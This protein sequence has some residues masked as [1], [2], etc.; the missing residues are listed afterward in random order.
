M[1]EQQTFIKIDVPDLGVREF[2]P[3]EYLTAGVLS[4]VKNWYGD[5]GLYWPFQVALNNGDPDAA[6]C[7]I[8]AVRR[9]EDVQPNPDPGPNG[10]IEDFSIPR[11]VFRPNRPEGRQDKGLRFPMLPPGEDEVVL[12]C[13]EHLTRKVMRMVKRWYP[14]FA[15]V[16]GFTQRLNLGD[17]DAARCALWIAKRAAGREVPKRPE[18][19]G[20]FSIGTVVVKPNMPDEDDEDYVAP[21]PP[22][23]EHGDE[24]APDPLEP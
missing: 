20:D 19:M 17:P 11:V 2:R 23:D 13:D 4:H 14:E 12:D 5:L 18:E 16:N 24:V 22:R 9:H 15:T 3:D 10:T 21:T 1:P 6:A 8:W 7:A